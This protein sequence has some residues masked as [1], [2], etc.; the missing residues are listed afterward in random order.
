MAEVVLVIYMTFMAGMS[1][2]II[3]S[4]QLKTKSNHNEACRSLAQHYGGTFTPGGLFGQPSF[5]FRYGS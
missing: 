1:L 3:V 4:M 5:R 2:F